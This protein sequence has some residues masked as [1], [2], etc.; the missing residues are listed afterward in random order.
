MMRSIAMCWCGRLA[1]LSALAF[2][3]LRPLDAADTRIEGDPALLRAVRDAQITAE[4]QYRR[5]S[6][7]VEID[8]EWGQAL[9]SRSVVNAVWEKDAIYWEADFR[10]EMLADSAR[11]PLDRGKPLK[12]EEKEISHGKQIVIETPGMTCTYRPEGPSAMIRFAAPEIDGPPIFAF[13]PRQVWHTFHC[14][15]DALWSRKFDPADRQAPEAF[16][17]RNEGA[18]RVIVERRNPHNELLRAVI[19]LAHGGRVVEYAYTPRSTARSPSHETGRFEWEQLPSGTWIV[20]EIEQTR[21]YPQKG[22]SA[23][24]RYRMKVLKYDPNPS[25][26]RD[27]FNVASLGF[28][29]G[30]KVTERRGTAPNNQFKSYTLGEG[31]GPQELLDNLA[32]ELNKQGFARPDKRD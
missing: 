15:P 17:V 2:W 19:S 30:T 12:D 23:V 20:R 14:N 25:I 26:P 11:A 29:P 13:R 18:D 9:H 28:P 8:D 16:V 1:V 4:A 10:W 22:D 6:M 5:G 7:T 27:R 24:L 21:R 32:E 3:A 31:P